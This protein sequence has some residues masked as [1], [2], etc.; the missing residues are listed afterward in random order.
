MSH[1]IAHA[2]AEK[3]INALLDEQMKASEF[4]GRAIYSKS[5]T[6]REEALA[7]ITV[8]AQRCTELWR[9]AGF[10]IVPPLADAVPELDKVRGAYRSVMYRIGGH[11]AGVRNHP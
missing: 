6:A 10:F 8:C 4:Q 1:S 11:M 5:A 2:L 3:A 7:Q 9:A